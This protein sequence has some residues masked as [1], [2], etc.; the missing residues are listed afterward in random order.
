M[1]VD[2]ISWKQVSDRRWERP[3]DGMESY[4]V[5]LG[6]LTAAAAQGREHFMIFTSVKLAFDA[7]DKAA[8]LRKAWT[9]LR[10]QIPALFATLEGKTK[11]Y[12]TPDEAG[13]AAWLAETFI[14]SDADDAAALQGATAAPTNQ[15]KLYYIPKSSEVALHA[16]HH[17]I[18]GMGAVHFWDKYLSCLANP[19]ADGDVTFGDEVA[20][21]CPPLAEIMGYNPSDAELK[22]K[23]AGMFM[24]WA[25]NIPGIGPVSRLGKAAP[26]RARSVRRDLSA[27]KTRKIIAASKARG[28]SVTAAV[29]AAYVGA[30]AAHADPSSKLGEYVTA[31]QFN[32]RPY[33]PSEYHDA[34]SVLYSAFPFKMSLPAS[35]GDAADALNTQYKTAIKAD[36]SV[37]ESLSHVGRVMAEVVPTPEFMSAPQPTDAILS[38]LGVVDNVIKTKYGGGVGVVVQDFSLVVDAVL[39][40]G[41]FMVYT[42]RDRLSMVYPYNDAYED[43]ESVEKY[44]EELESILDKELLA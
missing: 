40:M 29:H 16:H 42:F 43:R 2:S 15:A 3:A 36:P 27:D 30:I 19:A 11:V 8:A 32:L 25:A 7:P 44:M 23:A 35:Y 21:L 31:N 14:V 26:G 17:V 24:D 12:E 1:T 9:Q 28:I 39:G 20:R 4:F 38:S 5:V 10:V 22:Q 37:I 33:L 13:L 18:D 41:I 34:V 6:A